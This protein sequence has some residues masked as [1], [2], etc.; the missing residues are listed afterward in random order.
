M[1]DFFTQDLKLVGNLT[2]PSYL[3]YTHWSQATDLTGNRWPIA[4]KFSI[5]FFEKKKTLFA[6][7]FK[8]IN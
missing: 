4:D 8:L 7:S 3:Q 6:R 5:F 2:I 1:K